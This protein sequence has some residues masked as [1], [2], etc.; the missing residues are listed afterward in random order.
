MGELIDVVRVFRTGK[1]SLVVTI[2]SEAIHRLGLKP[3]QKL[4]VKLL[5]QKLVFEVIER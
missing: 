2:P 5:D 1:S 3:G 4:A